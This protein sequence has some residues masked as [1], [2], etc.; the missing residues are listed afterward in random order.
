M[1]KGIF[2]KPSFLEDSR[3]SVGLISAASP[4]YMSCIFVNVETKLSQSVQLIFSK[5]DVLIYKRDIL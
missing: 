3:L 4:G 2:S 1:S 5:L